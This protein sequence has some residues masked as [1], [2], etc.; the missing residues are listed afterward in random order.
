MKIIGITGKKGA[1]K[2]TLGKLLVEETP[3]RVL[4]LKD[5]ESLEVTLTNWLEP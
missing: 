4:V 5:D 3:E 2:D 1:G